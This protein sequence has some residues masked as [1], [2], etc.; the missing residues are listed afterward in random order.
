MSMANDKVQEKRK[1][2][3]EVEQS[4]DFEVEPLVEDSTCDHSESEPLAVF[5]APSVESNEQETFK[6]AMGCKAVSR[7]EDKESLRIYQV[8]NLGLT[9]SKCTMKEAIIPL[10]GYSQLF[11]GKERDAKD[12]VHYSSAVGF[13]GIQS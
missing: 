10:A 4:F 7:E 12:D 11:L 1:F 6:E 2:K 5:V 8:E 9:T 3:F 13:E